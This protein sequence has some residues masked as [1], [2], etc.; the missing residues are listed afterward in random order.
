[1]GHLRV[2][3][4][5]TDGEDII[6]GAKLKAEHY[7]QND[8]EDTDLDALERKV[9]HEIRIAREQIEADNLRGKD[10]GDDMWEESDE[11]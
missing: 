7:D 1:V 11:N 2:H 5:F 10:D 3:L 4:L 6:H 9:I 8:I